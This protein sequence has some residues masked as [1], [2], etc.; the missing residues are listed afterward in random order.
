MKFKN[1]GADIF[2][3]DGVSLEKALERTTHLS[4]ATHQ[5][6]TE[7]FAYHGIAECF[8]RQ[9]RWFTSVIVTNGA[10]SPRS[11]IYGN[12]TDEEMREIRKMEQRKAA[13]VGEYSVQIQLSYPSSAVKNAPA[14]D[15]VEDIVAILKAAKPKTVYL[16]NPAD[17]HDTHVAV[18]LRSIEALRSL[19]DGILPEKVYGCEV[20]RDL[21]WVNDDEKVALPVSEYKN[22]SAAVLGVFDSQISGGKRY[23]LAAA[24]RRLA[25]ATFYASHATDTC[26]A[27]SYALDLMP[28]L[29]NR[30]LEVAEFIGGRIDM[31]KNDVVAKIRKF[32]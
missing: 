10:G 3:P 21:D 12:F 23:D 28:L 15:V 8:G 30:S 11:G 9:D 25:N 18:L 14:K 5:D 2:V 31:F 1:S 4:V 17:K 6:D 20:W 32:S 16:H 7:I 24:G 26:D 29:K 22:L 19:A 13:I 27:L